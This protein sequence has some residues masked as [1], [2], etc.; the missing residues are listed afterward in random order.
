VLTAVDHLVVVV[1]DL[2]AAVAGYR[3]LGF[4]VTEGGRH[5]VA[6]HNALVGLADG[7]YI[8]LV[9]FREPAPAH[10]WWRALQR[11]GGLVDYCVAADDFPADV[12]RWRQAGVAL[13]GPRAQS[14][15]RPDGYV[16]HWTLAVPDD[17]RQGVV[18]FLIAD[19]T[20]RPERVPPATAHANGVT[21]LASLLVAVADLD[22]PRAWF[23]R[24]LGRAGDDR[25]DAALAARTHR[26]RLGPHLV[27]FAAP[28]GAASPLAAALARTGPGLW[29]ATLATASGPAGGLDQTLAQ[30][31]RLRM[32]SPT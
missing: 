9:A 30:G 22:E 14:R 21:A 3:A 7:C 28:E 1:P 31:A 32:V 25:H 4:T 2:A 15:T 23:A 6:T 13:D 29:A 26:V 11:G 24:V 18:P 20:P 8:E 27:E 19:R 17:A 12:E 16:L 5:A 10:R